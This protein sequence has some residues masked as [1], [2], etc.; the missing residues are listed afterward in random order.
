MQNKM[1]QINL[2]I[3][4]D[5]RL[6][7]DKINNFHRAVDMRKWNTQTDTVSYYTNKDKSFFRKHFSITSHKYFT[8]VKIFSVGRLDIS[9]AM[10]KS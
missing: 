10:R 5:K 7:F 8:N 4:I 1:Y 9:T 6:F 2:K 3:Y